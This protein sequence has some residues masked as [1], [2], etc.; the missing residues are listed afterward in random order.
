VAYREIK[1]RPDLADLLVCTWVRTVPR[2][3]RRGAQRVVPDGC[4]DLVWHGGALKVSGPDTE[5]FMSPLEPD[6]T[7]VGLRFRRG[8]AGAA[9]GLPASELRDARVALDDVW[10][11]RGAELEERIGLA[12]DAT[13]QRRI[14]E[15][16]VLARRAQSDGVDPAVL[17]AV[18]WLGHPG[19]HVRDVSER[20]GLS[21]RQLLRRFRVA[22]GY[23]PKM[24]DR[25]MRFQRFLT[26]ARAVARGDEPLAR[27]AFELGYSDQAHL[28]RECVQ[29]SGLT[30]AAL[31]QAW[32]T[33]PVGRDELELA[34]H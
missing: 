33:P 29:L 18:R 31:A 34:Q 32:H 13:E 8:V 9:L 12:A 15:E 6:A 14:L 22:V 19:V 3:T 17:G 7:V 21:D 10:P 16:A 20:L 11:R 5:P 2:S 25:V 4:V 26:R 23:G 1:P 27:L 24:L 28:T 30:P